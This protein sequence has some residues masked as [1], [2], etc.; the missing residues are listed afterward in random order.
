MFEN[1]N[2]KKFQS[3]V[4]SV[5]QMMSGEEEPTAD[6][7]E[8]KE[9]VEQL[10]LSED[11]WEKLRNFDWRELFRPLPDP[12]QPNAPIPPMP[13]DPKPEDEYEP[14]DQEKQD[15]IERGLRDNDGNPIQQIQASYEPSDQEKFKSLVESVSQIMSEGGPFDDPNW[16]PN[17]SSVPDPGGF[18]GPPAPGVPV[19]L[20]LAMFA[21]GVPIWL[22]ALLLG[23][24]VAVVGSI[25]NPPKPTLDPD[26]SKVPHPGDRSRPGGPYASVTKPPQ[27]S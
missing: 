16:S 4:D 5:R 1:D 21:G 25:V 19:L 10:V 27:S 26:P 6:N 20:I 14:T 24:S 22:I 12:M 2:D 17:P 18:W 9:L 7:K 13:W 11:F 8:F 15:E 3:L 23:I